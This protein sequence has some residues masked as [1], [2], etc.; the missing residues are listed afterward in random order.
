VL[1]WQAP[2]L[3][4]GQQ[5][6]GSS[7]GL[8]RRAAAEVAAEVAGWLERFRAAKADLQWEAAA[9][10]RPDAEPGPSSGMTDSGR[11]DAQC[12]PL[13]SASWTKP[14]GSVPC[15]A[16]AGLASGTAQTSTLHRVTRST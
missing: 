16:S 3:P 5:S 4:P 1:P 14:P 9:A 11:P 15:F 8:V 10:P 12:D 7:Y 13:A 2:N 6:K